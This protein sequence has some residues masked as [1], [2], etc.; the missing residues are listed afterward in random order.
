MKIVKQC[1]LDS[2]MMQVHTGIP[3]LMSLT[4]CAKTSWAKHY[5]SSYFERNNVR[6][7]R[8]DSTVSKIQ[9]TKA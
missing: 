2:K 7:W 4:G 1:S 5:R 6:N 9:I 8:K 3:H